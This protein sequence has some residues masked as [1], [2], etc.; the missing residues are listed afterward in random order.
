MTE[1]LPFICMLVY[2]YPPEATGGAERQCRLQARELAR[3]GC[4]C[5]VLTTRRRWTPPRREM[6]E[7][8]EV[9]RFPTV[10]AWRN[11]FRNSDSGLAAPAT[12]GTPLSASRL[13]AAFGL[14]GFAGRAVRWF[15]AAVF[16][17][18]ASLE[19]VRRR[20]EIDVLHTHVA[21]WNAG[22]AGWIGRWIGIPVVAKAAFLPALAPISGVPFSGVWT[23]W[24]KRIQ[25]LALT[26][27]MADDLAAQGIPRGNIRVVPNGVALPSEPAH[28]ELH[29]TVLYVG[30]L[31]Q[32]AAHKAF[33]VLLEAWAQVASVRPNARLCI[34]GAGDAAPWQ[35]LAERL[36]CAASIHFAGY[37][38]DVDDLYRQAALLV[39]P[40]CREGMSNALLEALAMGLPA[41]VSDIPGN[42]ELVADGVNG[43]VVPVGDAEA[44][45]QALLELHGDSEARRRMGA[46]ARE[47]VRNTYSLEATGDRL[48]ACYADL[49]AARSSGR[50]VSK[51]RESI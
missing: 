43:R 18:G 20:K 3:R 42:R 45:A 9:V 24:R 6:D 33:D 27:P 17:A 41:V 23:R 37:V 25:Y 40:S 21:D 22:F 12:A 46:A 34:A 7:G 5:L 47:H 4:R 30:N 35:A 26:E 32:G 38:D 2:S 28:P 14:A 11:R 31:T 16:M 51:T 19:L 13:A 36:G 44:L 39:L 29:S 48:F 10:E 15:N 1:R 50:A 49:L 8:C